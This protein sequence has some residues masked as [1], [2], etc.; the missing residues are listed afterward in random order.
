MALQKIAVCGSPGSGKTS[1]SIKLAKIILKRYKRPVMVVF[2][3]DMGS[4]L[5]YAIGRKSEKGRSLG[6]LI[7]NPEITNDEILDTMVLSKSE[8]DLAYL[9]YRVGESIKSYPDMSYE[10]VDE[11][12]RR[13]AAMADYIIIDTS[14]DFLT[15]LISSIA[16]EQSDTVLYVASGDVQGLA[17]TKSALPLI[18]SMT[19]T[20]PDRILLNNVK[21]YPGITDVAEQIR[22][23][24]YTLPYEVRLLEESMEGRMLAD[25]PLVKKKR[26]F[27]YIMETIVS[28]I[29]IDI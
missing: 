15:N 10:Q 19:N 3:Q 22:D 14:N 28:D 8:K 17:Y 2:A 16:L 18:T 7:T 26:S 12:Y 13:I 5:T 1:I 27:G 23:V 4:P 29:I 20:G 6:E 25:G 9:G 24:D 11:F 21:D